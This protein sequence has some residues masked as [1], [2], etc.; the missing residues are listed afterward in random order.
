MVNVIVKEMLRMNAVSAEV[1]VLYMS[2][3]VQKCQKETVIVKEMLRMHV[4][5]VEVLES[6]RDVWMIVPIIMTLMQ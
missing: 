6:V 1:R 5:N 2:V 4:V 3:V